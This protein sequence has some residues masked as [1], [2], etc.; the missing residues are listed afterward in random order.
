MTRGAWIQTISGGEFTTTHWGTAGEPKS[1]AIHIEFD[2]SYPGKTGI[3]TISNG[4]FRGTNFGVLLISRTPDTGVAQIDSITGGTFLGTVAL[5]NDTKCII[6]EIAGGTMEGS[7]GM[8]NNGWI[9]K[10]GGQVR[11]AGAGSYGIFNYGNGTIDEITGGTIQGVNSGIA[12][13]GTIKVISGGMIAASRDD[14]IDNCG[15]IDLIS[16][17]TIIGQRTAIYNYHSDM[18]RADGVLKTITNG[19]FWGKT[20]T[21][22][23]LLSELKLEPGLEA[24]KGFG[25]YWGQDGVVFNNES[26]VVYPV[27]ELLDTMYQM[28]D[29]TE[30]VEG[31]DAAVFKYL[32]LPGVYTVKVVN[33]YAET[34]GA[35][36]Y[37]EGQTITIDAGSPGVYT[38][39][40]WRTDAAEEVLRLSGA[41]GLTGEVI[42]TDINGISTTFV[43]PAKDVVVTATWEYSTVGVPEYVEQDKPV[44]VTP[45]PRP[46]NPAHTP[47][48]TNTTHIVKYK[49]PPKTGDVSNMNL[50]A[51]MMIGALYGI[52]G[53]GVWSVRDKRKNITK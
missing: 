22:I 28:S 35:G 32:M 24:Y 21:S 29:E 45:P 10:I 38:F 7:Q 25:R 13:A 19:V 5:Q 53:V 15:T 23:V 26:L 52:L 36:T 2:P 16:G 27:N 33:S 9:G 44:V 6:G 1:S 8:L 46:G 40:G 11:M 49:N 18:F 47:G 39:K 50:W 31:T 42:L 48:H 14:G 41:R 12:N 17:G 51:I 20:G 43:M 4:T 30:T 34:T 37:K 3:G